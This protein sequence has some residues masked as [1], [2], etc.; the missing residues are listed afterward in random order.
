MVGN[1]FTQNFAHILLVAFL[2]NIEALLSEIAV[3]ATP[4]TDVPCLSR[5]TGVVAQAAPNLMTCLADVLRLKVLPEVVQYDKVPLS[6][7]QDGVL[8][9]AEVLFGL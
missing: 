1:L 4:Q 2:T 9:V 3:F 8:A 6:V 7:Q 5:V